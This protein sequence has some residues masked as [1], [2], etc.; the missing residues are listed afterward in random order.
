MAVKKSELQ[1]LLNDE[2]A[3]VDAEEAKI[4]AHLKK[5]RDTY[6]IPSHL[7]HS[8]REELIRRY[9]VAGW[10]VETVYDQR[11]GDFWRFS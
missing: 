4:D 7:N 1:G 5:R 9:Q 6:D 11:D 10:D 8:Q 2:K 3:K